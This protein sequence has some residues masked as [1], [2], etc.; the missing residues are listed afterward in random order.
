MTAAGWLRRAGRGE[1]APACNIWA[2]GAGVEACDGA[3][4]RLQ[5]LGRGPRVPRPDRW[6]RTADASLTPDGAMASAAGASAGTAGASLA[7]VGAV[8]PPAT[9]ASAGAGTDRASSEAAVAPPEGLPASAE[10]PAVSIGGLRCGRGTS[11]AAPRCAGRCRRL[12]QGRAAGSPMAPQAGHV[13]AGSPV[14]QRTPAHGADDQVGEISTRNATTS[15]T[16]RATTRDPT[17]VS[18]V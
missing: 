12:P 14:A 6:L 4:P 5:R 11:P 18:S 13:E 2:A 7:A 10:L 16:G 15:T 17:S 8:T 3:P 1:G 9:A